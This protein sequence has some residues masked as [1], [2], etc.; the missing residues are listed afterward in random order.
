MTRDFSL[1]EALETDAVSEPRFLPVVAR[2]SNQ[3]RKH[4]AVNFLHPPRICLVRLGKKRDPRRVIIPNATT[5]IGRRRS[6]YENAIGG[7]SDRYVPGN[8]AP[9]PL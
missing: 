2:E 3:T 1:P 6:A 8:L 9:F 5:P 7:D 4:L